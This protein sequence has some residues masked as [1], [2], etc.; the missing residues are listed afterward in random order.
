[1][2]TLALA[3]GI[4]SYFANKR[5]EVWQLNIAYSVALAIAI[6][7]WL[8]PTLRHLSFYIDVTTTRMIVRRGL[9]GQKTVELAWS[10]ITGIEQR[11]SKLTITALKLN[12]PLVIDKLSRPKVLAAIIRDR[13]AASLRQ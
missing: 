9:F 4:V 12:G 3:A 13:T 7:F 10:E 6:F 11:G 1:M 2:L 5:F 8:V